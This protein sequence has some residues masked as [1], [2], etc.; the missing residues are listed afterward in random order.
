MPIHIRS[1]NIWK[2]WSQK[3]ILKG[4]RIFSSM[5]GAEK[6]G[7]S[8]AKNETEPPAYDLHNCLEMD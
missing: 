4:E 2:Q 3:G 5:N 6:T 1:T 8:L 7:Y